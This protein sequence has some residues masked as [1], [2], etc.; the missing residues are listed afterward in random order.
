MRLALLAAFAFAAFANPALA[1]DPLVERGR[2]LSRIMDCSGCHTEGALIGQPD[3]KLDLAGSTIGFEVPG[4]GYVYPPNLTS[5]EETGLGK[6]SAADIERAVTTGERP[7]G[8]ILVV[9][10]WP[11]YS[12]LTAEDARALA[13]Y[14][15]SLAPVPHRI[16]PFTPAPQP[17]PAPVLTVK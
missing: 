8:R 10:P 16:P 17:Q 11:S 1:Q 9:M 3:P 6:W 14:I 15:K 12:A 2:Y 4:Y 5:D 7:D 13:S